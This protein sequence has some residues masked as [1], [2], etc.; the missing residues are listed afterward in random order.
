MNMKHLFLASVV[1][2]AIGCQS[3]REAKYNAY[4]DYPVTEGKWEEMSYS[5]ASTRFSL[6]A[7]T[8]E[9]VRVLLYDKPSGGVAYK[10]VEMDAAGQGLWTAT[11]TGDLK[12]TYYVFN[13]K[14]DGVWRGD[15]P[16]VMAKAVGVNGQRAAVVDL[17]STDPEGWEADRRP[18]LRSRGDAVI[19]EMHYRDFTLDSVSGIR[20]KGKYLALTER[21]TV[22]PTGDKTG[23]DHL[24]ELGVTHVHLLPSADFIS[25]DEAAP[26]RP[27]YNWGY[28]PQNYNVPEGSYATDATL[29]EVRIREFKEMVK[30]LHAAGLRVVMD[31]VYNHTAQTEGGSFERT[32]PGYFYRQDEEGGFS[33]ASGC[34]NETASERAM[35]RKYIL[36]SVRYWV[37]EYHVDGF[38][39]DLM[40]IHD[41][42]TMNAVRAELDRIDPTLLLY[43]EGWTADVSPWPEAERA[44]KQNMNRLPGIAAFGDELRDGLRGPWSDDRKGAFLTGVPGKEGWV[45]RG[46]VGAVDHPQLQDTLL[47]PAW[48]AE[49]QQMISYV[50]C[51]DDLCL[52][53]RMRAVQPY[54]PVQDLVA[55][56]KLAFTAVLTSQGIPFLFAGDEMMRNKKGVRN[57]YNAPDDV[58]TI[59]WKNKAVYRELFDYVRLLIAMRKAHPCFRLGT[60]EKV[61]QHIEFL[62]APPHTVAF[63]IKG[64]PEGESWSNTIVILNGGRGLAKVNV[65][66]GDY[67]VVCRDGVMAP[68]DGA[69]GLK[70]DEVLVAPHSALI[71]HQ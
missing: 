70:G 14:I 34:G 37:E 2:T 43:G 56:Q 21:G 36:E 27:Q 50:S 57:S 71:I 10:M 55:L 29:P 47:P 33:N 8:A 13:V 25:V 38:R 68:N 35:V 66:P 26:L 42:E 44:V 60:A 61:R 15:T 54:A 40:G 39:F 23:V 67:K 20:N 63:C 69:G 51:H 41:I 1:S 24:L 16:G 19:Y 6:W 22:T 12:H 64:K 45:K 18:P 7:P 30:A 28:D 65:P 17:R 5:P 53:D 52:A 49:P 58:N 62:D 31:V 11:V 3:P 48:A 46:L 9:Q 4:S 32:V 59:D